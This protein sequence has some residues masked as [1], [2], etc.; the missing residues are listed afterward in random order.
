MAE[1]EKARK[2][3]DSMTRRIVDQGRQRGERINP[4]QAREQAVEAAKR[5]DRKHR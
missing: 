5:Y 2:A 3:I 1:H 4:E